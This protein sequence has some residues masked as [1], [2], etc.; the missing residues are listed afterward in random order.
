M[1][2]IWLKNNCCKNNC[3]NKN[4]MK[5]FKNNKEKNKLNNK[6]KNIW[7]NIIKLINKINTNKIINKKKVI[8]FG[9]KLIKIYQ[10]K[11]LIIMELKILK[12]LEEY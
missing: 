7:N 8:M 1:N 10:W 12:Y 2:K 6:L 3:G 11:F 5:K 4:K 9:K